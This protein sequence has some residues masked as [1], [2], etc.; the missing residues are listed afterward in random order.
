MTTP[1]KVALAGATGQLGAHI[2]KHLL[3]ANHPVVVLTR[4]DS[5]SKSKLP[6]SPLITIAE[7]DYASADS[8]TPHLNGVHTVIAAVGSTGMSGALS[9]RG[10]G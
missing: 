3:A 9:K 5:G 2:L 7:V 8:I 6:S 10:P 1:V 4:A